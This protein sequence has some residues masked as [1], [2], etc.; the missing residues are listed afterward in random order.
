MDMHDWTVAVIARQ[1]VKNI[2]IELLKN[3]RID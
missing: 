1:K 2:M 3:R